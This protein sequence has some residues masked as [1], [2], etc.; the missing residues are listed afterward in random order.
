MDLNDLSSQVNKNISMKYYF[1]VHNPQGC[2]LVIVY[3][4]Y[5]GDSD[6]IEIESCNLEIEKDKKDD[7]WFLLHRINSQI[8]SDERFQSRRYKDTIRIKL[9]SKI[10]DVSTSLDLL[11]KVIIN[12]LF[13]LE[14]YYPLIMKTLETNE[15]WLS[16][17]NELGKSSLKTNTE[18]VSG[19]MYENK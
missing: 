6:T 8:G 5:L 4:N 10:R 17:W 13:T 2:S 12:Y 18:M 7:I 15:N 19:D 14:K 9:K 3:I 16:V 11:E 1:T